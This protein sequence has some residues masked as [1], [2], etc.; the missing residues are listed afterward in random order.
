MGSGPQAEPDLRTILEAAGFGQW[1]DTGRLIVLPEG[2][3]YHQL[4]TVRRDLLAVI[5][6]YAHHSGITDPGY[7]EA[8]AGLDE[9]FNK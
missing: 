3:P 9:E 6:N 8:L 7:L 2:T 4:V 5:L 1:L